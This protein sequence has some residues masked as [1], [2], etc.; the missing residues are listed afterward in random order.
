L[1]IDFGPIVAAW[2]E[3]LLFLE[4]FNRNKK[5]SILFN[6]TAECVVPCVGKFFARVWNPD[7][8]DQLMGLKYW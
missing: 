5:D 4:V 1:G 8:V 2:T 3:A 6:G 7:I